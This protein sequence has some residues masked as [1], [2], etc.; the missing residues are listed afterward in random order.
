MM[1]SK[2]LRRATIFVSFIAVL[3]VGACATPPTAPAPKPR[4]IVFLVIDGLPQRQAVDYRDQLAPD[5]LAALPGPWRLVCQRPL[6]HANTDDGARPRDDADRR[7]TRTAAASSP[8]SGATRSPP[9]RCTT[10]ATRPPCISGTKP[11]RST[12]RARATSRRRDRRRRAAPRRSALEGDRHLRQGPRRH[13]AGRQIR[14]RLHVH[15]DT[16]AVR[17][18]TTFYMA[19]P[20]GTG[21]STFIRQKPTAVY[22][23][24]AMD[25]A[26]ATPAAYASSV[27]DDQPWYQR[28]GRKLPMVIGEKEA[29]PNGKSYYEALMRSPFADELTLEFARAAIDGEGLGKDDCPTSCR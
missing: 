5:G 15:G 18:R 3:A 26:A 8:T 6:R 12:A 21:R 1:T 2:V 11:I 19:A 4:L 22:F 29:K 9:S 24:T 25:T 20:P 28:Q 10:P 16:G 23:K 13:P 14:H 17:H 27:P 7:R